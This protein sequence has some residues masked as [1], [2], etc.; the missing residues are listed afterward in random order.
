MKASNARQDLELRAAAALK[1]VL[2]EVS[3]IKV[4]EIRRQSPDAGRDRGLMAFVDIFG[5]HHTLACEVQSDG[6]PGHLRNA[7]AELQS[8]AAWL[9][10]DATPVIIA[11]YFSPEAQA[12][13]KENQTGYVDLEGNARIALGEVFIVKRTL[14]HRSPQRSAWPAGQSV[15]EN[16]PAPSGIRSSLHP[17]QA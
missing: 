3:S 14:P 11:P 1:A 12:W 10:G 9:P 7:L 4:R 8:G 16:I 2:A 6:Q 17:V 15:A 13:C 5:H